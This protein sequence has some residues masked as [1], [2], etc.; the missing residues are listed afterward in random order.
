ME[1]YHRS[2][3][4]VGLSML[5]FYRYIVHT[6]L[7]KGDSKDLFENYEKLVALLQRTLLGMLNYTGKFI[8]RLDNWKHK[9]FKKKI[10]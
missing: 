5:I 10:D 2:K 6:G 3:G 4:C 8:D 7:S 9:K 1:L